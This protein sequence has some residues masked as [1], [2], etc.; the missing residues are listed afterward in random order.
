MGNDIKRIG[1]SLIRVH[2][3]QT[4][5]TSN[6][7]D[8]ILLSQLKWP[9]ENMFAGMRPAV[10]ISASNPN[11]YRDWHRM[12]GMNDNVI[13]QAARSHAKVSID[14]TTGIDNAKTKSS[15]SHVSFEKLTYPVPVET[16]DT[17][18]LQAH[19]INIYNTFK[20]QFFRDYMSYTYGGTNI[21]TPEDTGALMINFCLYPGTYQPSGH[22]N[23]SR[24]R[25]FYLAFV[26][27]YISAST[28]CD[29]LVLAQAINFNRH[30]ASSPAVYGSLIGS[31]ICAVPNSTHAHG[32]WYDYLV[33]TNAMTLFVNCEIIQLREHP[34]KSPYYHRN[35]EKYKE[36]ELTALSMVTT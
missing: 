22:I 28:P 36:L 2:R 19:G 8:N 15:S 20:A 11:Q 7:S 30:A 5:R 35:I 3:F 14:D 17:L 29:L 32:K 16:I 9:I 24:A 23:V 34:V 26:S 21:T 25:E 31:H 13:D 18:Q 4:Q 27:S 12:T 6:A 33:F 1:F 10:N